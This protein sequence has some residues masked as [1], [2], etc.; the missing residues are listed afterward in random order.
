VEWSLVST[1]RIETAFGFACAAV[2]AI[3]RHL[4]VIFAFG[5]DD[6]ILGAGALA[7]AAELTFIRVDLMHVLSFDCTKLL[8]SIRIIF[9]LCP[10]LL[11]IVIWLVLFVLGATC[12]KQ[13][14]QIQPNLTAL[15][16]SIC[17]L[18]GDRCL[19]G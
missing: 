19:C 3:I 14:K 8:K 11:S 7:G 10:N 13:K 15:F 2:N 18:P 6:R 1:D 9:T 16:S 4:I 5:V 12:G 17:R